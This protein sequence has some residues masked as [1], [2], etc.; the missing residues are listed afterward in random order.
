MY[1][2]SLFYLQAF[3]LGIINCSAE[4][5][6]IVLRELE[7]A[8]QS[9]GF[10]PTKQE[11]EEMMN[12]MDVDGDR[13]I[14]FGEF[15]MVVNHVKKK[16]GRYDEMRQVALCFVHAHAYTVFACLGS[17]WVTT[18]GRLL[19]LNTCLLN[20]NVGILFSAFLNGTANELAC[21]SSHYSFPAESLAGKLKI[22]CYKVF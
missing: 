6:L 13:T 18:T 8:M 9:L 10:N 2:S 21:F 1:Q 12:I 16:K 22:P 20:K 5:Y 7:R 14:D 17:N 4:L 19:D 15:C 3:S 11:V